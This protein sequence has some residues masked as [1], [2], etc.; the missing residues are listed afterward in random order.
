MRKLFFIV[1]LL[2]F[3]VLSG[4]LF[5]SS[6]RVATL[7][8]IGVPTTLSGTTCCYHTVV[9]TGAYHYVDDSNIFYNPVY[10]NNIPKNQAN[11][12][13]GSGGFIASLPERGIKYGVNYGRT[14]QMFLDSSATANFETAVTVKPLDLQ[15]A[16]T[17]RGVEVGA[18]LTFVDVSVAD[19]TTQEKISGVKVNLGAK[20]ALADTWFSYRLINKMEDPGDAA[21]SKYEDKFSFDLGAQRKVGVFNQYL[22]LSRRSWEQ[23][24]VVGTDNVVTKNAHWD[25]NIGLGTTTEDSKIGYK[26]IYGAGVRYITGKYGTASVS[27]IFVPLNTGLEYTITP[28]F[29][30]RTGAVYNLYGYTKVGDAVT[31]SNT[32]NGPNIGGTFKFGSAN[33]DFLYAQGFSQD[34]GSNDGLT[35]IGKI[36]ITYDW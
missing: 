28:W 6:V 8:A 5:A 3:C 10:L 26:I 27:G 19:G 25:F 7:G 31:K 14:D 20:F 18:G 4:S 32:T 33:F 1:L 36:A 30:L 17:L 22:V 23:T 29:T 13:E 21:Q 12:E 35:K 34:K 24:A 15:L 11:Y 2:S 9:S 16:T